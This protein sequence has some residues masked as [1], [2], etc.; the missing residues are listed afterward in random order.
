M[1]WNRVVAE[2]TDLGSS[3]KV[4]P[5]A[6]FRFGILNASSKEESKALWQIGLCMW[7]KEEFGPDQL[8][9]FRAWETIQMDILFLKIKERFRG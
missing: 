1:F 3:S 4:E 8:E 6:K 9:G 2:K 7:E 5:K